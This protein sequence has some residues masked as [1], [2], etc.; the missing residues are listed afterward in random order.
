MP[1]LWVETFVTQYFW[2]IACFLTLYV[3]IYTELIPNISIAIKTRNNPLNNTVNLEASEEVN[4]L[5]GNVQTIYDIK[6][7][8]A[9]DLATNEWLNST[10]EADQAYWQQ[11]TESDT[12]EYTDWE[13]SWQ[14]ENNLD[15]LNNEDFEEE[16]YEEYEDNN[17][18]TTEENSEESETKQ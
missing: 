17:E 10:P 14:T 4:N 5:N 7:S 12:L 11:E 3:F 8:E 2:L 18:E 9:K 13:N 6:Y 1:Q 16:D 15:N